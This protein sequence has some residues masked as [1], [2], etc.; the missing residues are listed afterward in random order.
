MPVSEPTNTAGKICLPSKPRFNRPNMKSAGS[1]ELRLTTDNQRVFDP[2]PFQT[3]PGPLPQR[4]KTKRL[5]KDKRE[6]KPRQRAV[7]GVIAGL[8]SD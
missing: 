2:Y 1:P 5:F 7:A 6:E 8:E 3:T 4:E